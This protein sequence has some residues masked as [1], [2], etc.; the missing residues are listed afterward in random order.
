[1]AETTATPT[2]TSWLTSLS[3]G[4][5]PQVP[6]SLSIDSSTLISLTA[7]ALI[8]FSIVLFFKFKK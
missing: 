7:V 5:L 4:K 6:V 8:I 3:Q 2:N 1:M